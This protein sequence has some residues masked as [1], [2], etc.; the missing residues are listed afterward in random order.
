[1]RHEFTDEQ[2][3]LTILDASDQRSIFIRTARELED[4]DSS[5]IQSLR[6]L[7]YHLPEPEHDPTL[8]QGY[9][10]FTRL[11]RHPIFKGEYKKTGDLTDLLMDRLDRLDLPDQPGDDA[12]REQAGL[13]KELIDHPF[14]RDWSISGTSVRSFMMSKLDSAMTPQDDWEACEFAD[15][16]RNDRVKRVEPLIGDATETIEGT[17]VTVD[18]NWALTKGGTTLAHSRDIKKPDLAIYRIPAPRDSSNYPDPAECPVIIVHKELA[19]DFTQ[20]PDGGQAMMWNGDTYEN[21]AYEFFCKDITDWTPAK[22][23]PLFAGRGQQ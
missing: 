18:E 20:T 15:I 2:L 1:M 11:R 5:A 13:Y 22:V 9:R 21:A 10:S 4:I 12:L 16:R 7:L 23:T 8:L 17:A 3:Q 19:Y 14:F 6:T